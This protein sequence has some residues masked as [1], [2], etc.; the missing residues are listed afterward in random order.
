MFSIE[1]KMFNISYLFFSK[2]IT[3]SH[4]F[5]LVLHGTQFSALKSMSQYQQLKTSWNFNVLNRTIWP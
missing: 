4:Y 3:D 5:I 2:N 1:Y